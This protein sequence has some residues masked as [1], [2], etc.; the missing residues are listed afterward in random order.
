VWGYESADGSQIADGFL[1][2]GR[3]FNQGSFN[4]RTDVSDPS[5]VE[6]TC[7]GNERREDV[8]QRGQ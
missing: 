3:W 7:A 8:N 6:Y 1:T 5:Y 4:P 2:I